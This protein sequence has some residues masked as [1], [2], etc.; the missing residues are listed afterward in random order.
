MHREPEQFVAAV[1]RQVPDY[2]SGKKVLE[3]GSLD[4]NGSVRGFFTDCQYTGIDLG[5]GKGVDVVAHVTDYHR[6]DD[7]EFDAIVSTE[8]LEH[9][10]AWAK[11]LT[12]MYRLLKP[13]GLLLVTCAAPNRP[14]HGTMRTGSADASPFTADYY[15]NISVEDF[16]AVLPANLFSKSYLGYRG[17]K[18]DLYFA[19]VKA[20][21]FEFTPPHED[22]DKLLPKPLTVTAEISTRDRYHTLALTVSAIINQT[23]KPQRLVIYDDGEQ[24]NLNELSPF[25]SLF[26]LAAHLG[27]SVMFYSTERKG[28]VANHQHALDAAETDLIWRCF[29]GHQKVETNLGLM[30][31]RDVQ[32]GDLVKTHL[33]RFK[34]VRRVFKTPYRERKPLIYV[35]TPNSTI[36]CTPD[37]PFYVLRNW[38]KQWIPARS[39][40]SADVLLYPCEYKRDVVDFNAPMQSKGHGGPRCDKVIGETV[41]DKKLARF[42]GLYLAEGCGGHD[43]I[44]FTFNNDEQDYIDFI[45]SVCV[46]LFERRPTIH[47][48]WATTVKLNIRSLSKV[49]T[50]WFGSDATEKRIPDFVR[51][52]T[53]DN[54]LAFING[55][56]E[57]DGW[58]HS[59]MSMFGI[60]SR[61]GAQQIVDICRNTG[62]DA[63]DLYT[64][65][66]K[67]N[68]FAKSSGSYQSAISTQ[69]TFK[70]LDLLSSRRVDRSYLGVSICSIE[71]KK[72]CKNTNPDFQYVYN[73]EVEDDN[74]YIVGPAIV[75]NCDDDHI[76]EPDCLENLLTEMKDGVGAVAGLVHHPV[77]V[78]PLPAHVTGGVEDIAR[79]TNV[80]WFQWN[81][82]P[83]EVEHLYS[84]FLYRVEAARK[85]GGYPAELSVVGHREESWFTVRMRQAGYKLIVTPAAKTYHLQEPT[86]GIRSFSDGSLWQHD[87]QLFQA[88]LKS[89]GTVPQD[90]KLVV[91]D[92]GLGDHLLFRGLLVDEFARKYPDR[93]WTLA[94]CYPE[95]FDGVPNVTIISI[96]EAKLIVGDRYE[97]YSVYAYAWNNGKTGHIL[98]TMREFWK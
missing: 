94:V 22:F 86:G 44:R 19:G 72:M 63:R 47:S 28:Q 4:I 56:L 95:V 45:S 62:L 11:S 64:A 2:F 58:R 43:S 24:R 20:V 71:Q 13:N 73:L 17:D 18:D 50:D 26:P 46:D 40:T 51:N 34:A 16:A 12:A 55:F 27:I 75:H 93:H 7:G 91:L 33:G 41:V 81:G 88:Y 78:I 49:F 74:S 52:W 79:G 97:D 77:G 21:R 29:L 90:S 36:K 35:K 57:G 5:E 82:G 3:V 61:E 87:D 31:I 37:H 84:T 39:L 67:Q 83:R 80:Q 66:P 1:K 38:T 92:V 59:N 9:D 30:A 48:R 23:V 69:A 42:L 70:M 8:T 6:L 60:A 76:P 15:R 85:A 32:V 68:S 54:K 10:H 53:L 65:P 14:E 96:A 89:I 25:S 98:D